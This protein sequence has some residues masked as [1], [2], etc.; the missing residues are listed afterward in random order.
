M[1]QTPSSSECVKATYLG[2]PAVDALIIFGSVLL[3]SRAWD[4]DPAMAMHNRTTLGRLLCPL[5]LPLPSTAPPPPAAGWRMT[6]LHRDSQ[7]PSLSLV[8]KWR[9][10]TSHWRPSPLTL[11]HQ[12]Q[13]G[14]RRFPP[15][16]EETTP[17][18]TDFIAI[19]REAQRR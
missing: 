15:P 13:S 14:R 9:R 19:A 1:H 4:P 18:C 3:N 5:P 12:S 8:F 2:R 16:L 11:T 10:L 7:D 17:T 6:T